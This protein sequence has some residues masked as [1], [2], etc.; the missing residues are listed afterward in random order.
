MPNK[1]K[2]IGQIWLP[3]Q[4]TKLGGLNSGNLFS[5]SS[6]DSEVQGQSA[7]RVGVWWELSTF[8]LCSHDLFFA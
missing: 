4:N 2:C 7:S 6:G 5:H 1:S 3:Q 8:P